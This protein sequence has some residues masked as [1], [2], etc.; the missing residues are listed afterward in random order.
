MSGFPIDHTRYTACLQAARAR[1]TLLIQLQDARTR[2]LAHVTGCLA[3]PLFRA[4]A[5]DDVAMLRSHQAALEKIIV[6]VEQQRT[7]TQT[8]IDIMERARPAS[9]RPVR[10]FHRYLAWRWGR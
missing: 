2:R 1:L 3:D 7:D 8:L 9:P 4:T 6:L 5:P 10:G